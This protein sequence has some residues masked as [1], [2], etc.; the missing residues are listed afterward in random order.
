MTTV[1]S[2]YAF[3]SKQMFGLGDTGY[4]IGLACLAVA[5]IWFA[6]WYKNEIKKLK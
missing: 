3:V 1:C 5:V 2:T 6:L 4:Y